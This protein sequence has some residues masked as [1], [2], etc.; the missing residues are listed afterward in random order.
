MEIESLESYFDALKKLEGKTAIFRGID[1]QYKKVPT[2]VRSFCCCSQINH[3][4]GDLKTFDEW[5]EGWNSQRKSNS[6]IK[7][8]FRDYESTLF[9]LLGSDSPQLAA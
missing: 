3:G 9:N 4:C 2:I 6:E 7:T 1:A 5:Y 8:K